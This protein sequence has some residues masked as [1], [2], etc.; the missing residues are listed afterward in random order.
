MIGT[1]VAHYQI[2]AKVGGGGMGVVYQARDLKLGRVVALKFLPPQWSHDEGAKQRFVREAQAA[3]ATHHKNICTIHN[4]E[5]TADGQLFIVMAYYEGETLKQRLAGGPLPIAEAI[6]IGAE[7]AE[8]LAKA[9]A[10]GVVHRDVK[11]GNVI[12]TEDG[13]KLVD[14][15]L[16]TFA[17]AVQL[18]VPGST[19]GTIAYMSPEQVRGEEA[20][21]RSDV[22]AWGIVMFQ[23]L[24]GALPFRGPY[25]EATFHAIKHEPLPSLRLARP[26]VPE[27]L[28]R[29]VMAA[30]AKDA[31]LR[32]P[33]TREPARELRT[34]QGRTLPL[35]L[36]TEPLVTTGVAAGGFTRRRRAVRAPVWIGVTILL[37]LAAGVGGWVWS[38]RP[39]ERIR[40]AIVPVANHTGVTDLDRYRL[41]LTSTLIDELSESPNIRVV[42]YLR[43]LEIVRPFILRGGDVSSTDAVQAVAAGSGA[44][45]LV[46]PT[47][48][49]RDRD[50]TWLVQIQIRNADTGTTAA[51]YETAPVASSLSQQTAFRLIA[52]AA[53]HIQQHFKAV[54][55]GRSFVQRATSSRFRV[56]DAARAFEQGQNAYEQLEFLAAA[57]AFAESATLDTQH[58]QTYAWLSRV[59]LLLSQKDNAVESARRAKTLLTPQASPVEVAF[60]D[61][62]F[63]ESQGDMDAA[64]R[65]YRALVEVESDDPW[66]Q[67]ELA[68]F[69]KRRQDRN[70]QAIEAYHG[71]LQA[72][73]SYARVHVDLCQLYTRVDDY[74][75][76]DKEGLLAL[77]T[78][79]ESGNASLQAQSLL[80]L[81]ESQR[82]SR[83]NF[84]EARKDAA[85]ARTLLES[86]RQP[87]NLARAVFYQGLV[88]Y[89][90]GRLQAS[91]RLFTE[92]ADRLRESG[93]RLL[94]ATSL[95][96]LG[97]V[98]FYLG[99]PSPALDFYERGGEAFRRL[100]DE[101]RAAEMNV[102][103][104]D[105]RVEYGLDLDGT[106]QVLVNA[107]ANLERLGHVDFQVGA[108]QIEGNAYRYAGELERARRLLQSALAIARDRQ[109]ARRITPI[110]VSLAQ[111]DI[112]AGRYGDALTRLN[113]VVP[114]DSTEVEPRIVRGLSLTAVGDLAAAEKELKRAR[115]DI[116]KT[117]QIGLVPVVETALG[118]LSDEQGNPSEARVHFDTAISAWT[119]PLLHPAVIEARCAR[120]R[121]D[122]TPGARARA[123]RVLADGA[124]DARGRG[125]FF[126]ETLC[127]VNLAE[128]DVDAG[129]LAGAMAALRDIPDETEGRTIGLEW[130]ARV[131]AV[132]ARASGPSRRGSAASASDL[133]GQIK[134]SLPTPLQERFAARPHVR[135]ILAA[136]PAGIR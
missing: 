32:P 43:L 25:P 44:R 54:G 106:R 111:I 79:R 61:A 18:T 83:R 71:V 92:A 78:S 50:A 37:L 53:D 27:A 99:R 73:P 11:P 119:D 112:Q 22:W 13:V 108:M 52:T 46:V 85:D 121:L 63:A 55:P 68:D 122:T 35:E 132:R 2:V 82:K 8:G 124:S 125:R 91:I 6:E 131:E 134:M 72:D 19:I 30:L 81:A 104:T 97:V 109:L 59:Q 103:A 36:R 86:L 29:V 23:M 95:M 41:A 40:V 26:D 115:A 3:S 87:D 84:A 74:P 57:N 101:R 65:A 24:A 45:F 89:S 126:I 80:C 67:S 51:T 31:S 102:N 105:L 76:A 110:E 96:N 75:L 127:R 16:A 107:R 94:E 21:A 98:N 123:R 5:E 58:A 20:D 90:D 70:Q 15:G 56:P 42:P 12:L 93:N 7:I 64:E 10:Q 114:E 116:D 69:L 130:R 66:T 48:V 133:L 128:L 39:I 28:E 136:A 17:D 88:E 118:H 77:A 1:T 49:Y 120:A 38:H 60:V 100:G 117:G 129:D 9:H 33:T 47:L 4:I 34:L 14:F 113:R 62:V 135:A